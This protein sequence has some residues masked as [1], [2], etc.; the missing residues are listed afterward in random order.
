M[1]IRTICILAA[2]LLHPFSGKAQDSL[3]SSN[4]PIVIIN[5]GGSDIPDEP[6]VLAKLAIV[7]HPNKRNYIADTATFKCNILIERRGSS[8][9]AFFPQISYSLKLIDSVG[10]DLNE[11]LMGMPEEH[12]WILYAPYNDKTCLRNCLSYLISN[13]M[14][15]YASRTKF[16]ELYVNNE[17]QGLYVWMEKIKRD[18]NRVDIARLDT[19][20]LTGDELTGGYIFKIDK[21]TSA[22]GDGCRSQYRTSNGIQLVYQY[23]YPH[24]NDIRNAQKKYLCSYIDSFE[25]S[26]ISPQFANP[27]QGYRKYADINTFIDYFILNEISRNVDGYR[28]STFIYKDKNDRLKIGPPWDYNLA[29]WNANYCQGS[30]ETGWAWQFNSYCGGD[31][32]PVPIWWDRM[33]SDSVFVNTLNCRYTSLRQTVLRETQLFEW[34]DSMAQITDEARTRHFKRWPI[35]GSYVWPNPSPIP[36]TYSE[37][38]T[39]IKNFITGRLHWLDLN[40]PGSCRITETQDFVESAQ[41]DVHPNPADNNLNIELPENTDGQI[42]MQLM[43]VYGTPIITEQLEPG[44]NIISLTSTPPGIYYF[45]INNSK[46][47]FHTKKVV[48]SR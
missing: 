6:K 11:S 36:N 21:V 20:D 12:D 9:Q 43:N 40:M 32:F 41:Y 16:C 19:A 27:Q 46:I 39:A 44:N 30:W 13:R 3:K 33:M 4:I 22:G 38:I 37:E 10:N 29:W 35:L 31:P 17:Y 25:N 14:G 24:F 42:K 2:I 48:V 15:M 1:P 26:L 7:D 18:K 28:L 34:I 45:V 5:Y 8:S 47:K 23:E